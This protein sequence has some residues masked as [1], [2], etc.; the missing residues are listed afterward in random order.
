MANY[1]YFTEY[2]NQFLNF[3]VK[4]SSI[5][6]NKLMYVTVVALINSNYR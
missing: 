6:H 5:E 1:Y 4:K 3:E 2:D